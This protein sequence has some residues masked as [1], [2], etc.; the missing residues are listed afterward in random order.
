MIQVFD[1]NGN[2]KTKTSISNTVEVPCGTLTF[3]L[4]GVPWWR[5]TI[6]PT[7]FLTQFT[8]DGG[9]TWTTKQDVGI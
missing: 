1:K 7:D 4:A 9:A 2:L 3:Y 5:L 8:P 6:T